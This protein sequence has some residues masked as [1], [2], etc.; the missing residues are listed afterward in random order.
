MNSRKIK[1]LV[2][3]GTR[4]EGIKLLPVILSAK[5]N[6]KF[7]DVIV[8]STAQHRE[9]LDQVLKIFNVKPDYDLNIMKPNQSLSDITSIILKKIENILELEKPDIVIVQGDTTT[10]MVSSLAAFYKKIKVGHVEA[11]L[12]TFSKYSPFP[13]EIN[14]KITSTIADFH[15]APTNESRQNLL[16]EGYCEDNIHVT[17]NTGIDTLFKMVENKTLMSS[18]KL[19]NL[20]DESKKIILVTAHRRESFGKS[21]E[22]IC[23]ALA[24]IAKRFNEINIIY[25]VHLN[26]NVQKPVLSI[27]SGYENIKLIKPMDYTRFVFLM[28]RSFII[29]TDSGGIQEEAPSLGKPVLVLREKTERPEAVKAGTVKIVGTN[30]EKIQNEVTRLLTDKKHYNSMSQAINPYGDG[31]ASERIIKILIENIRNIQSS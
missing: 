7:F 4:P 22:N 24:T 11:G 6:K 30:P 5:S 8:V 9:M 26:P 23:N 1:M 17:G 15:F 14:R 27:L 29:L 10:T 16:N 31:K 12:R 2:V 18:V 21:F 25:P 13:E 19:D 20:I 3:F 28:A